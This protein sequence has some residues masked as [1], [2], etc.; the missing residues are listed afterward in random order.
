MVI[1]PDDQASETG[2]LIYLRKGERL[3]LRVEGR[4]PND[5]VAEF[6]IKFGGSFIAKTGQKTEDAPTVAGSGSSS[7]TGVKVNSVGTIVAVVPKPTPVKADPPEETDVIADKEP[8][9][10]NPEPVAPEPIAPEPP[11]ADPAEEP[12]AETPA[13]KKVVVTS[14]VPTV[15]RKKPPKVSKAKPPARS[16]KAAAARVEKP[17]VEKTIVEPKPDPLASIRLVVELKDGNV[18]ERPMSEVVKFSV[19][20]GILTVTEKGGKTTRYSMITDVAKVTIQ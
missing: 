15:F 7:E 16:K 5:D 1:Y 13:T 8:E 4:S 3:V 2:R 9:P 14:D 18:I 10:V 17:P 11:K 12:V 19:D 6:R 20:K